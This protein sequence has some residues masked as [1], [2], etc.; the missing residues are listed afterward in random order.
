MNQILKTTMQHIQ[1][2][3]LN[4]T[5]LPLFDYIKQ[6][7]YII[8]LMVFIAFVMACIIL[9]IGILITDMLDIVEMFIPLL[10]I[11]F[12][13]EVVSGI[14]LYPT[15]DTKYDSS[16]DWKKVVE[17]LPNN[18]AEFETYKHETIII[19]DPTTEQSVPIATI[20][21][22]T[23]KYTTTTVDGKRYQSL[24]NLI[25][26]KFENKDIIRN[27]SI[28]RVDDEYYTEVYYQDKYY[29]FKTDTSNTDVTSIELE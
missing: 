10:I 12:I 6:N 27:L 15:M 17:I 23:G 28:R 21:T 9:V 4:Y 13:I 19:S 20:D 7:I 5:K 25:M 18:S 16:G 24:L 26:D 3:Q 22:N 8:L 14:I 1:E 11:I 29:K 2:Q